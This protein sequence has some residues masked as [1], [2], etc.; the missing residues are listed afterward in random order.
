MEHPPSLSIRAVAQRTGLTP[1]AIRSWE[2]R[3]NLADPARSSG[4]HRLYS[5]AEVDRLCL[6]A[7]AV[8]SGFSIGAIAHMPDS[9]LLAM[10]SRSNQA[11]TAEVPSPQSVEYERPLD[12]HAASVFF[13]ELIE[14]AE[15]FDGRRLNRVLDEAKVALGWQGLIELV[16]SPVAAEI[17]RLWQ[18][19]ELTIAQEHFFSTAVK[20]QLGSRVHVYS[21]LL[22]APRIVVATPTGQMHEL[23]AILTANA[24]ANMG[25][26]VAYIGNSVP[27]EELAGAVRK[28]KAKALAL[29]MIFPAEDPTLV[30]E[31]HQLGRLVPEGIRIIAGG[32]A[33]LSYRDSLLSIGAVICGPISEFVSVLNS[34]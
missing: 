13:G 15:N 5:E 24:A 22:N 34:I 19:G 1:F 29:S 20:V 6:L 16:I 33:A 8:K 3:Y 21:Q 12:A 26:E 2:R 28:F 7:R 14:A 23:G 27:A 18:T 17:G 9:E 31:I 30:S 32:R 11:L 4:G 25:W 10:I